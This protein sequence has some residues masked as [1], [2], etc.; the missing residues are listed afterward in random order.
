VW[1]GFVF[2]YVF[3]CFSG[4]GLVTKRYFVFTVVKNE[5]H[6]FFSSTACLID[7]TET[8]LGSHALRTVR[9]YVSAVCCSD[10]IRFVRVRVWKTDGNDCTIQEHWLA[11]GILSFWE[12]RNTT[13][14]IRN[15]IRA[16]GRRAHV[17]ATSCPSSAPQNNRSASTIFLSTDFRRDGKS[18]P[19][20]EPVER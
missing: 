19:T 7:H 15:V 8:R 6:L 2:E 4:S 5:K 10:G 3:Q 13:P 11:S 9:K 1:H 20:P 14:E 12:Y 18:R 17:C 16:W